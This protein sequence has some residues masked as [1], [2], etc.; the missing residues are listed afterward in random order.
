[1]D[2]LIISCSGSKTEV[3]GSG[4]CATFTCICSLKWKQVLKLHALN[5]RRCVTTIIIY[6]IATYKRLFLISN[7]LKSSQP[8]F[9][10]T[11]SGSVSMH[12]ASYWIQQTVQASYRKFPSMRTCKPKLLK[13]WDTPVALRFPTVC[14]RD[15]SVFRNGKQH[16]KSKA[17][18]FSSKIPDISH[19]QSPFRITNWS[20]LDVYQ[21]LSNFN[22]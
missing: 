11:Q 21:W 20:L 9:W 16:W 5:S 6:I 2:I 8:W 22:V 18:Q 1:M 10:F 12:D 3:S 17:N 7:N 19:T 13:Q 15:L 14:K 4:E